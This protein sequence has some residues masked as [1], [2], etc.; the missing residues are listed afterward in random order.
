MGDRKPF[1]FLR[2][3]G[4]SPQ[5]T[6]SAASGPDS[7]PPNVQA[8]IAGQPEG[9]LNATARCANH[10]IETTPQ[11]ALASVAPLP[12]S[13]TILQHIEDLTHQVAALST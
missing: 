5:T 4:A 13:N 9:D 1:Q 7:N 3:T 6:S 12:E 11:P 10:I 2:H 8:I